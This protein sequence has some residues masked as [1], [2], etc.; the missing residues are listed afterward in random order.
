MKDNYNTELYHY[1]ILGMKWGVLRTPAQL[2]HIV[3]AGHKKLKNVIDENKQKKANKKAEEEHMSMPSVKKTRKMSDSDI[4]EKIER[5][6]LEKE[7]KQL[8][9]DTRNERRN[10][11]K[12]FIA[13]ILETSGQNIL[14]QL[15]AYGMG[16]LVNKIFEK[17][18]GEKI[19]DPKNIQKKK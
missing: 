3:S 16:T 13:S 5:L 2:G 19:V 9:N 18:V 7:Y 10:R 15:S 12:Q 1:G 14:T 17:K 11:G 6:K 4:K 8:L